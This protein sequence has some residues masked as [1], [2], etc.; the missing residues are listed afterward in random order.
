MQLDEPFVPLVTVNAMLDSLEPIAVSCAQRANE[1]L[2]EITFCDEFVETLHCRL[3]GLP[4]CCNLLD[5]VGVA[6]PEARVGERKCTD[7]GGEHQTLADE[8]NQNDREREEENPIAVRKEC[9]ALD[10]E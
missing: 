9:S 6:L 3:D 8:R 1:V 7:Y 4:V 2:R 10:S 5:A